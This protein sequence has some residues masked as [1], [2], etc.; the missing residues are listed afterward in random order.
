MRIFSLLLVAVVF[1]S[2]CNNFEKAKS[3]M[4]YKITSSNSNKPKLKNGEIVKFNI[5]YKVKTK[6]GKDSILSST[7]GK[8]AGF[9]KI[10][11]AKMPKYNFTEVITK[12]AVGDK[13][14]FI[15]DN[16]TL[17]NMHMIPEYNDVFV[18]GG[19][20]NGRVE[21][22]K[23]FTDEKVANEE[24]MNEMMAA[25]KKEQEKIEKESAGEVAK[26][27]VRIDK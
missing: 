22:L 14:E 16:D 7:F 17:K 25:N 10:D 3:G 1:F 4:K 24:Y 26:E 15:L 18:K 5:E 20:V 27:K 13:I 21:I 9:L 12:L 2:S 19:V 8:A 23:V 11:T 6:A